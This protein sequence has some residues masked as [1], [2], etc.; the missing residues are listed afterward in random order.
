MEVGL[1]SRRV[2]GAPLIT[3][4]VLGLLT[5]LALGGTPSLPAAA[6]AQDGE[7]DSATVE[8]EAVINGR[9]VTEIDTND[10]VRL[11]PAEGAVLELTLTNASAQDLTVRSV[12]LDGKV[13]GLTMYNF[14]TRI[15]VLLPPDGVTT[16]TFDVD[17]I[18]LSGQATGLIPSRLQLLDEERN[19]LQEE[20]FPADIRGSANSVY[21][22]FG[23]AVLG[24][25]LILL[26]TLLLGIRRS[27]M[28][29]NRWRRAMRFVPV[30]LGAGF[31]LTFTLSATR[32]LSPSAGSW[33]TVVLLCG[34]AALAVGYFLPIGVADD[35]ESPAEFDTADGEGEDETDTLEP[36]GADLAA[37]DGAAPAAG[38]SAGHWWTSSNRE[39]TEQDR[40]STPEDDW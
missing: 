18:D 36:V 26:G 34:A 17:L 13:M 27:E 15:D 38:Q 3:V 28:P 2:R 31:V 24:I 12:R 37:A 1:S 30:G 29:Q 14:T 35:Q 11:D 9:P 7:D 23:L 22:I 6:A 32:Q 21:G 16:R 25:T 8:W 40:S 5:A 39:Q 4:V 10:P 20:S 19:V 33:T